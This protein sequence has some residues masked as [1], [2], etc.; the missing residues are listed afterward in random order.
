MTSAGLP[1]TIELMELMVFTPSTL[2]WHKVEQRSRLSFFCDQSAN[3]NFSLPRF[4]LDR[5]S[6][7]LQTPNRCAT[8]TRNFSSIWCPQK[9]KGRLRA[10]P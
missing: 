8:P 6:R 10:L 1:W 3:R 2:S 7:D 9:E 5:V 4:K